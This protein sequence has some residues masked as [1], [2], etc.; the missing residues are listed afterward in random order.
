M[1]VTHY[2]LSLRT[3]GRS[4]T[5]RQWWGL[6][7]HWAKIN[8]R[9]SNSIARHDQGLN[10]GF[11]GARPAFNQKGITLPGYLCME[12]HEWVIINAPLHGDFWAKIK[13]RC[14][15]HIGNSPWPGLEPRF[16]QLEPC[17]TTFIK[18]R[19]R[20]VKGNLALRR[21]EPTN[22]FHNPLL[23]LVKE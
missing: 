12:Y 13:M 7:L 4:R 18:Q 1:L 2:A 9:N 20:I 10:A 21:S 6:F 5:L 16:S 14:D 22:H 15:T 8:L 3:T 11:H 19:Q 17:C 23:G